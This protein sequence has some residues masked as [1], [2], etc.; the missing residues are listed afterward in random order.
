MQGNDIQPTCARLA[1]KEMKA[2]EGAGQRY[3]EGGWCRF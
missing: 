3:F 2:G 1:R